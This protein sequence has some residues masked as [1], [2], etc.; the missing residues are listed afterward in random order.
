MR[1]A[2]PEPATEDREWIAGE[3]AYL[4]DNRDAGDY[5]VRFG[6]L[7]NSPRFQSVQLHDHLVAISRSLECAAA[8]GNDAGNEMSCW[9]RA[10]YLLLDTLL[11]INALRLLA[12][13]EYI[14]P[15]QFHPA[16]DAVPVLF[17]ANGRG[18]ID[19]VVGRYL[20]GR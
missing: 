19:L 5:Q 16:M 7:Y 3:L 18:I 15:Q 13:R 9:N 12:S 20:E 14:Q 11:M 10:A 2:I 8:G 4:K 17:A 6:N 1:K